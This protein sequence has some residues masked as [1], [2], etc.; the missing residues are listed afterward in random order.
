MDRYV[1]NFTNR[2]DAKG[3][4]SIPASFRAVLAR[5][6][7][8]GLFVHPALGAPALDCGGNVLIGQID[9]FLAGFPAYSDERDQLSVATFGTSEVLRI[10]PEGRI[11]LTE[12]VRNHAGVSD[13]VTF[14][15][16]GPKFQLW[17]PGR[18]EAHLEAARTRVRDI[19]LG[20]GGG[21]APGQTVPPGAR[22]R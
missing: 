4:V 2:L 1:S 7:H 20:L 6:G 17:E 12:S 10:D 5:D 18:F 3:R 11:G 8:E 14:V 9:S 15:G 19:K 16:L 22:D 13:A 21:S